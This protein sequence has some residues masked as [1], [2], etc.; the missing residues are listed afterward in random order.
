VSFRTLA[1]SLVTVVALGLAFAGPGATAQAAGTAHIVIPRIGLNVALS[2][3]LDGG[4]IVYYRDADTLAIAGHRTTWSH[5]FNQLPALHRGDMIRV[6][7]H[8]Y[9][10][11][12]MT[13][14]RPWQTWIVN[15]RGLVLST[16]YPAGSDA[17]RY[18]V[19]AKQIS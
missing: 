2:R 3:T 15:Y 16:C 8:V 11:R 9:R 1:S 10:V 19:F 12:R 14:V 5:P 4:P 13:T 18:V 7:P 6:G 17:Y